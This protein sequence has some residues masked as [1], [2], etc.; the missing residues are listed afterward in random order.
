MA[1]TVI[2][3]SGIDTAGNYTVT[4]NRSAFTLVYYNVTQG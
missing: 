1:L 2:K 4:T 3:P